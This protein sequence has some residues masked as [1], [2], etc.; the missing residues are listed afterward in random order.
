[1]KQQGYRSVLLFAVLHTGIK[2]VLAA[3]HIDSRYAELFDLAKQEG[4]EILA[5][6]IDISTKELELK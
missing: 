1:M 2:S 5:Y 4:V 3:Q 6:N